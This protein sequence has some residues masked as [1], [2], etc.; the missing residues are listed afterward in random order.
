[1]SGPY[2]GNASKAARVGLLELP[3]ATDVL[4]SPDDPVPIG[5]ASEAGYFGGWPGGEY[6]GPLEPAWSL[7]IRGVPV[8]GRFVLRGGRFVE[9][10]YQA[11]LDGQPAPSL[12]PSSSATQAA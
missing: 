12:L 10:G 11:R 2:Y 5:I 9:L 7:V 1:M 4:A 3:G 6:L 8:G